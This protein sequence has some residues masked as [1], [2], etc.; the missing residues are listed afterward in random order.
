MRL[1]RFSARA[2]ISYV[3]VV[4]L[5]L[6]ALSTG[7]SGDGQTAATTVLEGET[8]MRIFGTRPAWDVE[9]MVKQSDAVVIAMLSRDLGSKQQPGIGDP[10]TFNYKYKDYELT[11]EEV[12]YSRENLPK[13]IA[14]LV[15]DGLSA[16]DGSTVVGMDDIPALQVDE[17]MLLFL[18][19]LEGPK[20]SEGVGRPVPKGFTEK[21]YF[22]VIIGS[23]FAKLLPEGDK[24]KDTHSNQTFTVAQLRDAIDR[25]K[26]DEE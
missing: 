6:A 2:A 4:M 12:I 10:P 15:E 13:Q 9:D 18:E 14:V 20:F 24:W 8:V 1:P 21:T 5:F 11:V 23:Q 16:V 19:S 26:P 17:R 22:Q 3:G 25:Q 7:C